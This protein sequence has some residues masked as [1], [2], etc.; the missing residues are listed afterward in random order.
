MADQQVHM[1]VWRGDA[2]GGGFQDYRI[3]VGEGLHQRALLE[4]ARGGVVVREMRQPVG[5]IDASDEDVERRIG[6]QRLGAVALDR[7][8]SPLHAHAHVHRLERAG[9]DAQVVA[10]HDRKPRALE[11]AHEARRHARRRFSS[12]E[13]ME[14]GTFGQP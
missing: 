2:A 7:R 10:L 11:R 5:E 8:E 9:L 3:A 6:G 13:M 14:N 1:R 12:A 4:R